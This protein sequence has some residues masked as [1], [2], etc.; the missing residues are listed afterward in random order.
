MFTAHRGRR[1]LRTVAAVGTTLMAAAALTACAGGG[2]GGSEG[3]ADSGTIDWWGWT[4]DVNVATSYIEAF[5]EEYPDIKVNYKQVPIEDWEAALRPAL[6]TSSGPDIFG[7]QPG[8]RVDA[9]KTFAEDLTPLAEEALGADWQEK[10][11][12]IGIDGLT[13][14]GKLVAMSV[15]AVYAGSMW[16]NQALFDQVGLEHPTT[17]DEWIDA[18]NTFRENNIGCFVQGASQ[19]GFDQDTLQ[20]IAERVEPGAWTEASKGERPWND[21]AIVETFEIWKRLFTDGIMQEGAIGYAQYPDANNDFMAGEYAMIMMGSWYTQYAPEEG[22]LAAIGAAGVSNPEPFP[23]VPIEFPDVAG[24]GNPAGYFGDADYGLALSN[25]SD[26]KAAARTFIT[27]LTTN[28]DAQQLVAD[29]LNN[30]PALN[31]AVPNWENIKLPFPDVQLEALQSYTETVS[32]TEL[33]RFLHLNT[34]EQD[35][36]LAAAVS[37]AE[38]TATPQEAAD[39]MQSTVEALG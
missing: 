7:V 1:G 5:N 38:G 27:W 12:Q 31:G 34:D 13:A 32:D 3:S 36:I 17:L 37:I 22:M 20:A 26:N 15:G 24:K 10:V 21:P 30:I 16:V 29:K 18:C 19:E 2:S 4:P 6:Q 11:S 8:S 35:A 9:F 33:A 25:K 23:L 14:D 28:E 39:T